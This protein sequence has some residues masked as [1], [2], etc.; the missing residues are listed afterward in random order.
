MLKI[1]YID[2]AP[3]LEYLTQSVEDWIAQHTV[4]A[5]RTG[6]PLLI[7]PGR[8]SLLLPIGLGDMAQFFL[9][10]VRRSRALYPAI[11]KQPPSIELY[12][13]DGSS[14]ELSFSGLWVAAD[15]DANVG[16]FLT[17]HSPWVERNILHLWLSAQSHALLR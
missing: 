17:T 9:T 2:T 7:E 5:L 13:C 11:A 6:Q 1:T 10:D 8:A 4:L 16:L 15:A 3:Q 12:P 14:L